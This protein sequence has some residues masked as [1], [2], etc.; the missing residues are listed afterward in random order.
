MTQTEKRRWWKRECGGV[1][2]CVC[3]CVC[4]WGGGG[5]GERG[6]YLRRNLE[7]SHKGFYFFFVKPVPQKKKGGV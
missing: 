4:V 3:V 1:C 6:T 5:G 2:V 7:T